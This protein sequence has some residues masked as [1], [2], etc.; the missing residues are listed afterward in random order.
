MPGITIDEENQ[1]YCLS[2]SWINTFMNCPE[3]ARLEMVGQLP[4]K[5]SDATA[6]GSA[7]HA[8]VETVLRGGS[9][10]ES[11]ERGM[12]L[13]HELVNLPEF[14]F[15][16]I[17]TLSTLVNT[18]QRVLTQWETVIYPELPEI[19][20][21][22]ESFMIPIS[23]TPTS[24]IYLQGAV[25]AVDEFG[26]IWDWKTA[27][28]PYEQWQV[29]R[30]KIQPTVYSYAMHMQMPFVPEPTTF[31]YAVAMKSSDAAYIYSTTRDSQ[32]WNWLK[33]QVESIVALIQAG[34]DRWPMNDQHALC[35]PKWCTAWDSCKGSH[36]PVDNE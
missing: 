8:S 16:Q 15:V 2:Q 21:V 32:H 36:F 23:N 20:L 7:L 35:S 25:D 13:L 3:Q 31:H 11:Y 9:S 33:D 19:V 17:K 22:E 5:E 27:A 4:R 34:L 10:K 12:E 26:D 28:R 24:T 14:E 6:I 18:F 29:D 1:I 30:Y